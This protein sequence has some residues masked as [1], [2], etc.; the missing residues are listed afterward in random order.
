[1]NNKQ[2]HEVF[3]DREVFSANWSDKENVV[4]KPKKQNAA[5]KNG[6]RTI[7]VNRKRKRDANGIS[8][9][10]TVKT[11]GNMKKARLQRGNKKKVR[12]KFN[13]GTEK[14]RIKYN[15]ESYGRMVDDD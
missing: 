5:D 9:G 7:T 4:V 12:L 1:M 15:P 11:I 14:K 13:N 2:C 6:L 10:D 3:P 8:N